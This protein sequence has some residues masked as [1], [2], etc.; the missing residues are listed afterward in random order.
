[1]PFY[2]F[3]YVQFFFFSS[4]PRSKVKDARN[5]VQLLIA[6][7]NKAEKRALRVKN[8][9]EIFARYCVATEKELRHLLDELEESSNDGPNSEKS[10]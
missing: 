5:T 6:D 7:V 3:F 1:M 4:N 2:M 9:F 10:S 8:D